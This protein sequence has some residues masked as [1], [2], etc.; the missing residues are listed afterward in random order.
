MTLCLTWIMIKKEHKQQALNQMDSVLKEQ[1]HL[2]LT[3]LLIEQFLHGT[4]IEVG[5]IHCARKLW[6]KTGLGID[7]LLTTWNFIT[8]HENEERDEQSSDKGAKDQQFAKKRLKGTVQ[9]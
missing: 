8:Q 1:I 5:F 6:S 4:T 9:V 7:Q 3:M 2:V